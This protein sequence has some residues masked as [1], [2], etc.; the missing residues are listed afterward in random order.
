MS[1]IIYLL[2]NTINGKT[3]VGLTTQPLPERWK[4]HC[5]FSRKG[6]MTHLHCAIRKHGE[7]AFTYQVL[8]HTTTERMND[9]ERHYIAELQSQYNMTIGGEGCVGITRSEETRKKMSASQKG[10]PKSE[11]HRARLSAAVAGENHPR[12]GKT[13][14]QHPFYG[15][16]HTDETRRK[17]QSA[18]SRYTWDVVTPTGEHLVVTNLKQYCREHNISQPHLITHGH[19]KGYR[20]TKRPT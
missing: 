4:Q 3:Y 10:K 6:S 14:E 18:H 8:E 16:H 7:N 20:A 12:Y 9:R 1:A 11:Q 17:M 2:T 19:T 5:R 13:G 15:K